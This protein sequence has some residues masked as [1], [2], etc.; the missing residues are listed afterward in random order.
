MIVNH[1]GGIEI[2]ERGDIYYVDGTNGADSNSGKSREFAVATIAHALS[3]AGDWDTIVVAAGDY[4]EENLSITQRGLHLLGDVNENIGRK[5]PVLIGDDNYP[6]ITVAAHDVVIAGLGFVQTTAYPIIY[7]GVVAAMWRT[8]IRDCYFDGYG[9]A[10]YLIQL[11][12]ASGAG[13][14]VGAEVKHCKFYSIGT[15]GVY[16]NSENTTVEECLFNIGTAKTG[17]LDV[18]DGSDRPDRWYLN[19]KFMTTDSTNGVG[20]SFSN[21]PT[22]GT[23]CIAGSRFVNFA[24]KT[25]CS[26]LRTGY[27]A[28]DN[29]D[30]NALL[31]DD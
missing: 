2:V 21:T 23:V 9:T 17:I 27:L 10:T 31:A 26:T 6:I 29:Y 15:A 12:A 14:A 24:D 19:N 20:I 16:N 25:K 8:L 1:V 11:G 7:V 3:L 18:P 28:G 30:D 13:E 22:K 4:E 5:S